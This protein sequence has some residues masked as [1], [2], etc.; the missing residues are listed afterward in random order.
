VYFGYQIDYLALS[1]TNEVQIQSNKIEFFSSLKNDFILELRAGS[2]KPNTKKEEKL[3][4][5]IKSKAPNRDPNIDDYEPLSLNKYL[6][7]QFLH[8]A[9]NFISDPRVLRVLV[10]L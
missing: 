5:S 6:K 3:A 9:I 8:D 10:E 2:K 7:N 1:S 4:K